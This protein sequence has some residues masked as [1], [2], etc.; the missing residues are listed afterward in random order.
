MVKIDL[1]FP[2][3]EDPLVGCDEAIGLERRGQYR[4]PR[5]FVAATDYRRFLK[6]L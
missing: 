2:S 6:I 4:H 3:H 5:G 1:E